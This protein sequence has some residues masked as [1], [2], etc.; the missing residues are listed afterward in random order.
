MR[1]RR[2]RRNTRR[3]RTLAITRGSVVPPPR[4][5]RSATSSSS[6]AVVPPPRSAYHTCLYR[7]LPRPS[8]RCAACNIVS[9]SSRS[10]TADRTSKLPGGGTPNLLLS[11]LYI[12]ARPKK[13]AQNPV[14]RIRCR[15]PRKVLPPRSQCCARCARARKLLPHEPLRCLRASDLRWGLG[16]LQ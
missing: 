15:A 5:E 1:G 13:R 14:P 3:E 7:A 6:G 11:T 10:Q 8:E 2:R 12:D 4:S 9:F 16:S